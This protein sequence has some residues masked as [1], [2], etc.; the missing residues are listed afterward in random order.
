MNSRLGLCFAGLLMVCAPGC[1]VFEAIFGCGYYHG[2]GFGDAVCDDGYGV[3]RKCA[4]KCRK[5]RECLEE[6]GMGGGYYP[7]MMSAGF[8]GDCGCG[9]AMPTPGCAGCGG[10]FDSSVITTPTMNVPTPSPTPMPHSGTALPPPIP[11]AE[12]SSVPQTPAGTQFVSVE[13]FHRL[14]GVVVSG[15]AGQG[16][17]QPTAGPAI[18][19]QALASTPSAASPPAA[20]PADARP[21][22][23][24][25]IATPPANAKQVQQAAWAPVRGSGLPR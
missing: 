6:H 2:H 8:A 7:E 22:D 11:P 23:S 1:C 17:A 15:P 16:P 12:T 14:P 21:L 19:V 24:T 10:G 13:E 20:P 18:D 5:C 25:V 3:P 4:K 9:G